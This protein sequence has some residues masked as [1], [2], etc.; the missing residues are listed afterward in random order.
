VIYE[1]K[2]VWR[3]MAPSGDFG[4]VSPTTVTPGPIDENYA[5]YLFRQDFQMMV[6]AKILMPAVDPK[7]GD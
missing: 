5:R 1:L 6:D 4:P 3:N 2:S 7:D